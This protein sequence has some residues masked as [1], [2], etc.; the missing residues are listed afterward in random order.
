MGAVCYEQQPGDGCAVRLMS[1]SRCSGACQAILVTSSAASGING[2]ASSLP[3]WRFVT[4]KNN[5][6]G[7][8]LTKT[9][10]HI[11]ITQE[12]LPAAC[13]LISQGTCLYIPNTITTTIDHLL[14]ALRI[15]H[16]IQP[17]CLV[18]RSS[19]PQPQI[20]NSLHPVCVQVT[21]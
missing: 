19:L 18:Y 11:R 12:P 20:H 17:A 21:T 15:A 4:M 10:K 13:N 7:P 3:R 14:H 16:K 9:H 6:L 1:A 8:V 5:E 2:L